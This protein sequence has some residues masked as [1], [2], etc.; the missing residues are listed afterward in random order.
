MLHVPSSEGCFTC[1]KHL[2]EKYHYCT[3]MGNYENH[4]PQVYQISRKQQEPRSGSR[5][6]IT[7]FRYFLHSAIYPCQVSFFSLST[8]LSA[9]LSVSTPPPPFSPSSYKNCW[10]YTNCTMCRSPLEY[11]SSFVITEEKI[12]CNTHSMLQAKLHASLKLRF[13][14]HVFPSVKLSGTMNFSTHPP[15]RPSQ[16]LALNLVSLNFGRIL[17]ILFS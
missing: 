13:L 10:P 11:T 8:P 1:R 6:V 12:I 2:Y 5:R 4:F 15:L 9:P 17:V 3:S 14:K 7:D 16:S